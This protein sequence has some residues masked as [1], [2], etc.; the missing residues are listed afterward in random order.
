[1]KLI[2]AK[3]LW[4]MTGSLEEQFARIAGAGYDA[5]EGHPDSAQA[6]A[7]RRLLRRHRL[8]FIG[9]AFTSGPDHAASLAAQ[10]GRLKRLAPLSITVHGGKDDYSVS[11]AVRFFR[12]A[13]RVEARARVPLGHETHRG[14]ILFTPWTTAAVLRAVP[15]TRLCSDFSH[16]CCVTESL[17]EG[18]PR[19]DMDL[20][21]ARTIHI[22]ARVGYA[23]G[24]QVPD[25]RAPEW[26]DALARHEAW[27]AAMLAARRKAG[28]RFATITP[29]FGPPDYLHTLPFTRQPVADLWDICAWMKD[30]LRKTFGGG[31][32]R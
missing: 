5:V 30:R 27:W 8:K 6:P 13:A 20:A 15:E 11:E 17:L 10:V 23:E 25:P 26:A 18:Q 21:V 28:A 9:M 16:W 32:R 3:S 4:G 14:R 1:M 19:E 7:F 2:I 12:E 24:P 22:H 31:R 29:E